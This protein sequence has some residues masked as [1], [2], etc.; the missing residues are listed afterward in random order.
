M[1]GRSSEQTVSWR[2]KAGEI[3]QQ[4]GVYRFRDATG[5]VLYVG[6]AKTLRARLSNYFAPLHTLHDR[7]RAMILSASSVE[8]TVVASEYEALHLEFTWIQE[9]KP[10][11]GKPKSTPNRH[12]IPS[13]SPERGVFTSKCRNSLER[14]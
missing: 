3:P 9:F 7:T 10:P 6:K 12:T 14:K 4:P 11:F 2:P 8:W 1:A 5:R 13:G